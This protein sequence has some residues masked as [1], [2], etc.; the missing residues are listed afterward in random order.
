MT[1]I[2]GIFNDK[3]LDA[4]EINNAYV[5]SRRQTAET[6]IKD[7]VEWYRY[8]MCLSINLGLGKNI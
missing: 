6:I 5:M 7:S 3:N 4:D 8:D 2:S 1:V